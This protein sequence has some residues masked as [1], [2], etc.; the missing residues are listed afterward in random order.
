MDKMEASVKEEFRDFMP[1]V[2]DAKDTGIVPDLSEEERKLDRQILR[3]IDLLILPLCALNYFFS[4]MDRSD[5]GNAKIAGF[6]MAIG[7]DAKQY[8]TIVS[9]FYVG[10]LVAQ[11]V[12]SVLIGHVETWAILGCCNV[13]WG[14][15]TIMLLFSKSTVLPSAL[16]VFIGVSEGLVQINNVFLTLWYTHEEIAIRTG[17]WY[18]SGVL[19][20]SFNG[21]IA[22]GVSK[23]RSSAL[24]PW[25]LL[26]L[27]E[28]ILPI[29]FGPLLM[30]FYPSRPEHV[31][32][33]FTED[34]KAVC[35][36]R[37]KRARNTAGARVTIKGMLSIF[38]SPEMYLL[39][40]SYFC[41]IWASSG[42]GNFLPSIVKGL[43]FDAEI[44]QLLTVPIVFLG[45]LSV[46]LWCYLSDRW[47]YRGP[48]IMALAAST[49]AGF[50]ILA[51]VEHSKGVRIFGLCLVS[52]SSHPLIPLTLS[53]LFVNTVGFSRRALSIPMQ[54]IV[55]QL[56]GL[57][58][59]YTFVDSPRYLQGTYGSIGCLASLILLIATLDVYFW[60]ENRKKA[61]LGECKTTSGNSE[62]SFDELGTK[63][64]NFTFTL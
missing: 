50:A 48:L 47:Q 41:V 61:R 1:S 46:N 45:F 29:I 2:D 20:G 60:N 31:K 6:Q 43:G 54:N 56:G 44:S 5:I 24:M 3:K 32:K 33:F 63:H 19:A 26:F 22:Y 42:F 58:S 8:S 62:K 16:R 18:S 49:A 17:I 39:W 10:Y 64:P 30:Y 25:Q 38:K 11:P 53:F 14:F 35:V 34:E 15:M 57:A 12:G 4:S 7:A 21:L 52:F 40:L 59:S 27:I 51:G 28:G 36:A 37:T 55:G 13:A 23:H 9:L